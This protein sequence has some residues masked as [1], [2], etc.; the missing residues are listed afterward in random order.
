MADSPLLRGNLLHPLPETGRDE[1]FEDL[2]RRPEARIERIVSRGHTTPPGEW[3][4]QDRDEW[5]MVVEGEGEIE[6]TEPAKSICLKPGD[7]IFIPAHHRHR[8]ART[9]DPT[10][11]LA[12]WI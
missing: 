8:V 2:L 11:W 3:F 1:A 6:F 7:W 5:V 4:D 10:V 12:V 9:A